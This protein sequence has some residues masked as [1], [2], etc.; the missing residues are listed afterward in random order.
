MTMESK[1]SGSEG[2]NFQEAVRRTVNPGTMAEWISAERASDK[3]RIKVGTREARKKIADDLKAHLESGR[4]LAWGRQGTRPANFE[5]IAP[6]EWTSA[7]FSIS[8]RSMRIGIGNAEIFDLRIYPVLN[9]P[10]ALGYLI[11]K[12]LLE[13]F[14]NYVFA[15]PQVAALRKRAIAKG[16]EPFDIGFQKRLLQAVWPVD[17]CWGSVWNKPMG[18]RRNELPSTRLANLVLARRFARLVQYFAKG[19][20]IAEGVQHR[21]GRPPTHRLGGRRRT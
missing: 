9:A 10:N 5:P 11:D 6:S 12:P 19:E 18:D 17:Y 20:L 2:W 15:D 21:D 3:D 4:L 13:I 1:S 14:R 16:G 8:R 7:N